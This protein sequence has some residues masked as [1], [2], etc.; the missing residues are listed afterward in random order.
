M[1]TLNLIL[2]WHL[3]LAEGNT[4]MIKTI[5]K[6]NCA[7]ARST[8]CA[9]AVVFVSAVLRKFLATKC[10]SEYADYYTRMK[11]RLTAVRLDNETHHLYS[12]NI[13]LLLSLLAALCKKNKQPIP[14]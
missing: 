12:K 3:L 5:F 10:V 4:S 6:K 1:F 8:S 2:Q 14:R 7:I 9:D 11:T 13:L